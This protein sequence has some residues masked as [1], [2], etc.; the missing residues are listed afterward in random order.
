MIQEEKYTE[1]LNRSIEE[2]NDILEKAESGKISGALATLKLSAI[3]IVADL[4]RDL[5]STQKQ[6]SD[7][8][9]EKKKKA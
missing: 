7:F 6:S 2:V 3:N 1:F 5:I 9:C 8:P 4:R